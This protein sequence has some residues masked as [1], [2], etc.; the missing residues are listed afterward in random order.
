MEQY[1]SKNIF[2]LKKE[3]F[4]LY[5]E[6][7]FLFLNKADCFVFRKHNMKL[8]GNDNISQVIKYKFEFI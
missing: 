2:V 8:L 5:V 1:I 3:K 4:V 7:V 6:R